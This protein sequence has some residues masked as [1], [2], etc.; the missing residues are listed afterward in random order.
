M[1]AVKEAPKPT[2]EPVKECAV[3]AP[4]PK[5]PAAPEVKHHGPLDIMHRFAEEMDQLFDEFG[6]GTGRRWPRVLARGRELLR[7]EAGLIQADWSPRVEIKENDG[8]FIV[9]ADLPG[10]SKDDVHV[11][12]TDDMLTLKGER[13]QE[14][15]E[16][17]EGYSYSECNYGSFYR[18]IPLPEGVDPSKAKAEF[19]NGTLEVAMPAPKRAV[20]QPRRIEVQEKK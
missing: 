4:T 7:R 13:K 10:L 5:A 20:S 14:K 11:E 17:R 19:H 3:A 9:R 2:T 6:V 15:K 12:F 1:A 16:E 8:Q 18:A